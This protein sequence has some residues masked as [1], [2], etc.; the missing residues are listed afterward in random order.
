MQGLER[1]R[2]AAEAKRR[3][4]KE[5]KRYVKIPHGSPGFI[6]P[7]S[8]MGPLPRT[9]LLGQAPAVAPYNPPP[10][11]NPSARISDYNQSFQFNR[12][13][14]NNPTDRDAYIRYNFNR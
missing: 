6:P 1:P 10:I 4:T 11:D 12:G 9:P 3:S 5:P 13:L 2:S 8:S 14:G 7:N